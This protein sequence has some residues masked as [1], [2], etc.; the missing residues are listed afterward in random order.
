MKRIIS[1]LLILIICLNF[2]S[3]ISFANSNVYKTINVEY[4]DNKGN[5][6]TLNVMINGDD[7]YADVY[8][9]AERLGYET[10]VTKDGQGISVYKKPT[11][12]VTFYSGSTKVDYLILNNLY[13]Y[14]APF[15]T[16]KDSNGIWVPFKYLL[17][18]LNSNM[19]IIEDTV[20]ISMPHNTLLT[21]IPII[22]SVTNE[23]MFEYYE[24]MGMTG[25]DMAIQSGASRIVNLFGGIL[26]FEG[27]SW[28]LM[29]QQFWGDTSAY[30]NKFADE[31]STLICTNSYKELEALNE[32]IGII[33]DIFSTDGKLATSLSAIGVGLD[34]DVGELYKQCE[35]LLKKINESNANLSKYNSTYEQLENVLDKQSLFYDTGKVA[36]GLQEGLEPITEKIK[37]LGEIAEV[38]GYISEFAEKDDFSIQAILSYFNEFS[39]KTNLPESFCNTLEYNV[40]ILNSN[41]A[42][43]SISKYIE[44]NYSDWLQSGLQIS[45]QIGSQANLMLFA[46]NLASATVP[47]IKNG[48]DAA[49]NFELSTYAYV[50]QQDAKL[51]YTNYYMDVFEKKDKV[52][53]ENCYKIAQYLYTYL[54][55][56][57]IAR[58]AA[59]G[60]LVQHRDKP[61][62]QDIFKQWEAPNDFIAKLLANVKM[63]TKN[64]E[65][66]SLGFLPDYSRWIVKNYT[67]SDL[68]KLLGYDINIE[69]VSGDKKTFSNEKRTTSDERDIVLVLDVSGSMSGTPLEETKKASAKFVDTI[70]DED[71]SIGVITY[72]N[73]A[74]MV[75]DFSVDK[76]SLTSVVD[77]ISSGGGTNIESGLL[78]AQEMLSTSNAKKK[79]I[80]LMSDGEPNDGKVGDELISYADRIKADGTY[81][82]TLGF[83]QSMSGGKSSA[84]MLMEQIASDGCH[85]EV[86]NADDLVFFFGD[87]ADQIN[88][89]KYI[90]VRIACPV[91]VIAEY[92]GE[93]LCSLK[94]NENVR[95]SFGSLTFEDSTETYE[96]SSDDRVKILRLKDD[97]DYDI[98]IEGNGRGFMDYTI[99]FMDENGE[100]GDLREFNDIKINK[101]TQINTVAENASST[102]LKVDSDGDGKYDL[103]Y[104]AKANGV[105]E[106]VDYSYILYIALGILILIFIFVIYIKIKR[107]KKQRI[108]NE[109]KKKSMKKKFCVR[110]G[111]EMSGEKAYCENC[112]NKMD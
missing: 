55:S 86:S 57:Y 98:K 109:I 13:E 105:G 59:I 30:D 53:A 90:Y 72:D 65:D 81:I 21:L 64:N 80:V 77:N 71:A 70:L 4:S 15:K 17:Y 93:R 29:F 101:R 69:T 73:S 25:K 85:Y 32:K 54:K 89:Q 58:D 91:D 43:Y 1:F 24:D 95:T 42:T 60:S 51:N 104:K 106:I 112:G 20:T 97:F 35:D 39:P 2:T 111:N 103:K 26:E 92:A 22:G 41:I 8:Q 68:L 66:G 12:L 33:T 107:W 52:N 46:W 31:L 14:V 99:G 87:I 10:Q 6:E 7:V 88:G 34:N 50:L 19:L 38:T 36:M 37:I 49:D 23:I 11:F 16:I 18:A 45:Q 78:K 94:E 82:Y 84:Q 62:Y 102:V 40:N 44:N 108:A 75:S 48:L 63:L 47:F 110:C 3:I 9:L 27:E 83:F 76:N 96:D 56:A 28:A 61:E 5:I 100:Y 67:D 79:I 74:N